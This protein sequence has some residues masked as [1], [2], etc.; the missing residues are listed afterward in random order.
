VLYQTFKICEKILA[1]KTIKEIKE[2]LAEELYAFRASR[3]TKDLNFGMRQLIEK[4]L[5]YG[6]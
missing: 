2:K 1:N 5:E 4:N 3:V 6:K